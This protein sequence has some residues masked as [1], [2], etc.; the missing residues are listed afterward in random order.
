M[1]K[2]LVILS[3]ITALICCSNPKVKD[4]GVLYTKDNIGNILVKTPYYISMKGD[5][6]V[7]GVVIHYYPNKMI[8]DSF[9]MKDGKKYGFYYRFDSNGRLIRTSFF[10]DNKAEGYVTY[11]YPNGIIESEQLY[12]KD[13]LL[14]IK[15]FF[16][17]GQLKQYLIFIIPKEAGHDLET[18][19]SLE[20]DSMGNKQD[21]SG[22]SILSKRW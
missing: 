5:T 8:S 11:F 22:D 21:E 14:F 12:R 1:G 4:K 18:G 9:N 19:Y 15:D 13:T 20:Y 17:N 3:I 16:K 10:D 6:L 2:H 7:D